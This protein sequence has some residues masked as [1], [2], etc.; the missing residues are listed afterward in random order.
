MRGWAL[1]CLTQSSRILIFIGDI[2]GVRDLCGTE[3]SAKLRL[4][5]EYFNVPFNKPYLTLMSFFSPL[6]E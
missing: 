2:K 1:Q 4:N 3:V 6:L 5:V